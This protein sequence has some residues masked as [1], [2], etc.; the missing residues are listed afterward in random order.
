[1]NAVVDLLLQ[2]KSDRSFTDQPVDAADIAA[3]PP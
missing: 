2:H 1:M 3:P